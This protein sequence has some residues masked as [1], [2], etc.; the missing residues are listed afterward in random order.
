MLG[1]SGR[2]FRR[3]GFYAAAGTDWDDDV[4]LL[5]SSNVGRAVV[6]GCQWASEG[7]GWQ[8]MGEDEESTSGKGWLVGCVSR[9]RLTSI[10]GVEYGAF[11]RE[12]RWAA[13]AIG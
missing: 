11:G 1:T 7:L 13:V 10:P 2:R 9:R 3:S 12:R 8:R 5:S 4:V 6:E